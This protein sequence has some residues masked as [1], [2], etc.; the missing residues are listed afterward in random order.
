MFTVLIIIKKFNPKS[1]ICNL[2]RLEISST[3]SVAQNDFDIEI[4]QYPFSQNRLRG[5]PVKL[6]LRLMAIANAGFG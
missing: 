6:L 1:C 2:L 3:D 4:L 5:L